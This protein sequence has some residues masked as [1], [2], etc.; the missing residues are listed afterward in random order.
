M[1]YA[2]DS[3]VTE[4]GWASRCAIH[5][6]IVNPPQAPHPSDSTTN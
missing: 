4:S 3:R 1:R 2:I 6:I 5:E